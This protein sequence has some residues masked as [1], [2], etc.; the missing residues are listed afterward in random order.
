MAGS[1]EGVAHSDS[2]HG[3]IIED[4]KLRVPEAVATWPLLRDYIVTMFD[5]RDRYY[6]EKF[7]SSKTVID[8]AFVASEK[9]VQAALVAQDKATT[10]AFA[11]AEKAVNA[12]LAAQEKATAAA[13][14]ASEKAITKAED[15]QRAY[16]VVS[17]EFRG[18]LAEQVK[19]LMTRTEGNALE[20]KF[21]DKAL[22]LA[23]VDDVLRGDIS[24]LRESRSENFGSGVT[25]ERVREQRNSNLAIIVAIIIAVGGWVVALLGW[26]IHK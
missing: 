25:E 2:S 10:A 4:A 14:Q 15:A 8:N 9:A 1:T 19:P 11:A 22:A 26:A 7:N 24:S 21:E 23:K 5:E 3:S 18:Q 16:N 13:F 6:Q 20:D 12:A 17:E